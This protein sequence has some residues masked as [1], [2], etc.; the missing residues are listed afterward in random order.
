MTDWDTPTDWHITIRR[1]D[2]DVIVVKTCPNDE[3]EFAVDEALNRAR[4]LEQ[5]LGS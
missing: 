2:G 3:L 5:A 4:E 1:N